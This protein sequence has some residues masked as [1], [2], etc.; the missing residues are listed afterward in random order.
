LGC[1]KRK[2][3]NHCYRILR[4][5]KRTIK[6]YG[7]FSAVKKHMKAIFGRVSEEGGVLDW[8][9]DLFHIIA[10]KAAR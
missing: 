4:L 9:A 1:G 8:T 3:R 7:L 2:C 6:I 10:T 5:K